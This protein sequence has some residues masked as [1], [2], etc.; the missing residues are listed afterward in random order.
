MQAGT[1]PKQVTLGPKSV[2]WV[3]SEVDSWIEAR[4]AARDAEAGEA[5]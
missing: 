4:I 1:F 5:K 3:E 2:G